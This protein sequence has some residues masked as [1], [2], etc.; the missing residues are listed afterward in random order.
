MALLSLI[1][2]SHCY[3]KEAHTHTHTFIPDTTIEDTTTEEYYSLQKQKQQ[4][5]GSSFIKAG[6]DAHCRL[7]SPR[8]QADHKCT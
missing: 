6:V 5:E 7:Q 1:H 3:T 2:C 8:K 4:N